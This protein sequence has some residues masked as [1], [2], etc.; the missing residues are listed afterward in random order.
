MASLRE[1]RLKI[2][3]ALLVDELLKLA[4]SRMGG[5]DVESPEE[6]LPN[7]KKSLRLTL[8]YVNIGLSGSSYLAE[9]GL[10]MS[11]MVLLK[12][13]MGALE[14][15][16]MGI[17]SQP[18]S[19]DTIAGA[20]GS[21][22]AS[23]VQEPPP[24]PVKF[25]ALKETLGMTD[26]PCQMGMGARLLVQAIL[27]HLVSTASFHADGAEHALRTVIFSE[28]QLPRR[29]SSSSDS[30]AITEPSF[31]D[32]MLMTCNE[33]TADFLKRAPQVIFAYDYGRMS[34]YR[35]CFVYMTREKSIEMG[36][37]YQV[38]VSVKEFCRQQREH[39]R[40]CV[41]NGEDWD[42]FACSV[43]HLNHDKATFSTLKTLNV[44]SKQGLA[45]VLGLLSDWVGVFACRLGCRQSLR[46]LCADRVW[47][48]TAH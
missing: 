22:G 44:H 35:P 23:E 5:P 6:D 25:A 42:F 19:T 38:A 20:P 11:F 32:Y 18:L 9:I 21:H 40:G 2:T 13:K 43:D 41:T 7:L 39:F 33:D 47:I 3:E 46:R 24:C 45:Q 36:L 26:R 16:G 37:I 48:G 34:K 17:Q 28:F 31:V 1:S 27:V 10:E 29:S 30:S 15:L 12:E 4:R 14:A 8:E